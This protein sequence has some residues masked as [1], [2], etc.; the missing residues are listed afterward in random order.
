MADTQYRIPVLESFPW[1]ETV[2]SRTATFPPAVATIGDRYLI[3]EE[4]E[5]TSPWQTRENSIAWYDGT[6]WHYDP[7]APGWIVYVVDQDIHLRFTGEAWIPNYIDNTQG[8]AT[9]ELY[10]NCSSP[11]GGTGS[12]TRPFKRVMDAIEAVH[13]ANNNDHVA[14]VIKISPGRYPEMVVFEETNLFNLYFEGSGSSATIIDSCCGKSLRSIIRNDCL[15]NLYFSKIGFAD[16]IEMTGHIHQTKL[17][18]NMVFHDCDFSEAS[19]I[20]LKNLSHVIFSGLTNIKGHFGISNIGYCDI[21]NTVTIEGSQNSKEFIIET[22]PSANLPFIWS[23]KTIMRLHADLKRYI[24]WRM[25]NGG[26]V[27]VQLRNGAQY[28]I[29]NED[30]YVPLR[31]SLEAINSR[32]LGNYTINGEFILD[33]SFVSGKIIQ[34]SGTID[35]RNQPASQIHNDSQVQGKSVADALN[36]LLS[37]SNGNGGGGGVDPSLGVRVD[38]LESSLVSLRSRVVTLENNGGGGGG[39]GGTGAT[40]ASGNT[41]AT[42]AAGSGGGSGGGTGATGATGAMGPQGPAG[43][44]TGS[45][46]NCCDSTSFIPRLSAVEA[47]V[48][49]FS[50][51][52]LNLQSQVMQYASTAGQVNALQTLVTNQLNSLQTLYTN[53]N[54]EV[55]TLQDQLNLL[56]NT[57]VKVD[58]LQDEINS[59]IEPQLQDL[60]NRLTNVEGA[61]IGS[62]IVYDSKLMDIIANPMVI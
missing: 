28:G 12:I 41:G 38:A 21:Y 34:G 8:I 9:K 58:M 24:D 17:G 29:Y 14:Y 52:I 39:Q 16:P 5:P 44:G 1:Q 36:Y 59:V 56:D 48:N 35:F 27:A 46:C 51:E 4:V 23:G 42:G 61:L 32:L 37:I 15:E 22:D 53:I 55:N 40:G 13:V 31:G 25:T 33:G 11:E 19:T 7:P 30:F 43:T 18:M 20:S 10:V 45:D 50:N 2:K 6:N 47:L 60:A 57:T 62:A 3:P 26:N 54:I 49:D